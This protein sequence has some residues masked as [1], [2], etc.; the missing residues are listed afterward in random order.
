MLVLSRDVY[1]AVLDHAERDVPREACG[2]LAGHRGTGDT[3]THATAAFPM[4]NAAETPRIRYA[5]DPAAL[6]EVIETIE[7]ASRDVVG[8]YHSH[9]AGP[10]SPSDI[11]H[12]EAAW[13][14]HHYLVVSL[15]GRPPSVDAWRWT[16]ERFAPDAV[17]VSDTGDAGDTRRV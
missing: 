14:D 13:V 9:P 3:S 2:V 11:D 6:L 17:T 4:E 8:F 15:A 7:G 10:S 1:D 5:L 12:S 16:G